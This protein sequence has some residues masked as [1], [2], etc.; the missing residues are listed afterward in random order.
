MKVEVAT[1]KLR[2]RGAINSQLSHHSTG[3]Q[4]REILK[5]TTGTITLAGCHRP[6][7]STTFMETLW[8]RASQCPI[9][10]RGFPASL[11]GTELRLSISSRCTVRRAPTTTCME[12]RQAATIN[13]GWEGC[14]SLLFHQEPT[15]QVEPFP[16]VMGSILLT[17][18][19]ALLLINLQAR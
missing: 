6:L 7:R 10:S 16:Q 2:A 12:L 11:E 8:E 4:G 1:R 14:R 15:V 18:A 3:A 13:L 17:L 5:D 9:T 19:R